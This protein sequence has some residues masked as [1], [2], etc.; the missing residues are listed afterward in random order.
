MHLHGSIK[1]LWGLI[2]GVL[3]NES[4]MMGALMKLLITNVMRAQPRRSSRAV[5][6]CVAF[7]FFL[8]GVAGM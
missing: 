6:F 7:A 5:C 8:V 4:Q 2:A 3:M 1:R